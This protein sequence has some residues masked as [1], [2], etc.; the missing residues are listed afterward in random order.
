LVV[1]KRLIRAGLWDE[2][3]ETSG[4][5]S[6]GCVQFGYQPDITVERIPPSVRKNAPFS[7]L[8]RVLV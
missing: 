6:N 8:L 1:P 4:P 2:I 3:G 5:I 7:F